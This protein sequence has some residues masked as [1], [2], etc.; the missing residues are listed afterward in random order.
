MTGW[1]GGIIGEGTEG[2][3]DVGGGPKISRLLGIG[4][5]GLELDCR[6]ESELPRLLLE[7]PF[8]PDSDR[9]N[10]KLERRLGGLLLSLSF[11]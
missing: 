9:R 2:W 7:L 1:A 5:E 6:E 8:P 10:P 11:S 4:F 3:G